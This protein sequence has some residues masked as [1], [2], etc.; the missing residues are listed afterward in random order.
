VAREASAV[1]GEA[2]RRLREADGLAGLLAASFGAFELIRAVA[3]RCEDVAPWLLAT[4]MTA[5]D[6]AVDGRD[7]M[8]AAPSLVLAA[9]GGVTADRLDRTADVAVAAAAMG[10]LGALLGSRLA[11]G[12]ELAGAAK[13]RAACVAGAAAGLRISVLLARGGDD[14]RPG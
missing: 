10:E 8:L 6:A 3:R 1:L 7:A 2:E 9:G 5:A 11:E 13:D 12:A 14:G 4:F